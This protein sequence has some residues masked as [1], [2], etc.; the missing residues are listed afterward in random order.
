[1]GGIGSF[2][3]TNK[4]IAHVFWY[5]VAA[6][7]LVRGARRLFEVL[8]TAQ[9]KRSHETRDAVPSRPSNRLSQTY[10]T[11]VA[12]FR[13]MSYPAIQPFKGQ[14]TRYF[15]PP[16][17]GHCLFLLTFWAIILVMLWTDVLLKPTSNLY[18][19]RWEKPAFRAAWVSITQVPLIYALSCKINVISLVTGVSYE[20]LNWLHRWVSRTL[21]LTVIVHWAYFFHEWTLADFVTDQIQL[22][23]MVKYGFG[24]WAVIG[25]SVIT[26]FGYFRH[27]RYEIWVLQHLIG[28]GVLL[29]LLYIHVP[30]Y[31]RYN[32]WMAVGF[33]A[34]DRGLRGV[35]SLVRN[36]HLR[37]LLRKG[38][39]FQGE[40]IALPDGYLRL[41]LKDIDFDWK[42]GQHVYLSIPS[43]GIIESHPFTIANNRC[44]STISGGAVSNDLEILVKCHSG[45]TKRLRSKAERQQTQGQSC[46]THRV[47][48]SGPWGMPPLNAVE[49]SNTLIF[50]SSSTGASY[51]V[52]LLEHAVKSAPFVQRVCFYWTV[53]HTSQ[54]PWFESRL[55]TAAQTLADLGIKNIDFRIFVTGLNTKAD[56]KET[57]LSYVDTTTRTSSNMS[58]DMTLTTPDI[59]DLPT[60]LKDST[61][62]EK[63]QPFEYTTEKPSTSSSSGSS[64]SLSP[65]TKLPSTTI[66]ISFGRPQSFD[67]LIR[68]AVEAALGETVIIACGGTSLMAQVRTYV[69]TLSD[70]RAVHK[71]TGAQGIFFWGESYGW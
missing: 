41:T 2:T 57:Q 9:A 62:F 34:F 45:F 51:T 68:P 52:P 16:P 66:T 30:V 63:K 44:G 40:A 36:L 21:F 49:R 18:G 48:L 43:C 54:I 10:E 23:P 15:T 69:A 70:E 60:T 5:L 4:H 22:M 58:I 20:R 50:I 61:I 38:I 35:W 37:G 28:A 12:M 32:I 8:R 46:S 29:W 33:V 6:T 64:A 19:Y 39:G 7:C 11:T 56:L 31:A 1:M 42:A 17:L 27:I 55:R 59:I 25:W 13:E 3:T 67:P 14:F 71:G 24:A 47:F 26:G 53:R 65:E